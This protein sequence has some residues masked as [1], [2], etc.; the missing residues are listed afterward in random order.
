MPL[1]EAAY[2]GRLDV[3]EMLLAKGA[4]ANVKDGVSLT[5]RMR[6]A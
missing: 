2:K 5:S 6:V 4:D 1:H 3:V